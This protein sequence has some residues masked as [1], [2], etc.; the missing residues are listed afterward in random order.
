MR[1]SYKLGC[2]PD[3]FANLPNEVLIQTGA[4]WNTKRNGGTGQRLLNGS[5]EIPWNLE[6]LPGMHP[7]FPACPPF[8]QNCMGWGCRRKTAREELQEG[9]AGERKRTRAAISGSHIHRMVRVGVGAWGDD[10]CGGRPLCRSLLECN[11]THL[12]PFGSTR[13]LTREGE[14]EAVTTPS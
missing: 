13:Y 14:G 10:W 6:I 7:P 2:G 11:T 4:L 8:P 3:W 12:F 9:P 1:R 5:A